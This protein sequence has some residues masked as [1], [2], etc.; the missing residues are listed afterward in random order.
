MKT[1]ANS[2]DPNQHSDTDY[3]YLVH[4]E[5]ALSLGGRNYAL[6][7]D[8]MGDIRERDTL[9]TTLITP[10]RAT[11][12]GAAT[13]A[14]VLRVPEEGIIVAHPRDI[15]SSGVNPDILRQRYKSLD[16]ETVLSKT[17]PDYHNEIVVDPK[18]ANLEAMIYL[19]DFGGDVNTLPDLREKLQE[20]AARLGVP[21][22]TLPRKV[23]V[24][25]YR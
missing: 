4:S 3:R 12:F 13:H 19:E 17:H 2:S 11:L 24:R 15:D 10:D 5:H 9:S 16:A 23:N 14:L 21:L 6:S 8:P 20:N 7:D 18:H 1:W 25:M 22:L